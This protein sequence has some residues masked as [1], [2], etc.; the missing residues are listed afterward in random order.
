MI[1]A[2]GL[3]LEKL[4]AKY[5]GAEKSRWSQQ[6]ITDLIFE[7]KVSS[8]EKITD[9]SGRGI[10]MSAVKKMI[11]NVDGKISIEL[12]QM[13]QTSFTQFSFVI[14]CHYL[15]K[16]TVG[17]RAFPILNESRKSLVLMNR[18]VEVC[19]YKTQK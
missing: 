6:Q 1:E 14:D 16:S 9:I 3:D 15:D 13:E 5:L 17:S 4:R 19:A 12:K 2:R 11:E 18:E 8:K 7:D 10:G